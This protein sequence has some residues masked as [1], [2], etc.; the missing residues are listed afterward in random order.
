MWRR[1]SVSDLRRSAGVLVAVSALSQV[2]LEARAYIEE[3]FVKRSESLRFSHCERPSLRTHSNKWR[4]WLSCGIEPRS[5][6]RQSPATTRSHVGD[7]ILV[8]SLPIRYLEAVTVACTPVLY[9]R[10]N[11]RLS[12]KV[13]FVTAYKYM[14][15]YLQPDMPNESS[16]LTLPPSW[17]INS[18]ASLYKSGTRRPWCMNARFCHS[19]THEALAKM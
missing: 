3:A 5:F 15:Y 7:V 2:R 17:V 11:E 13:L 8:S 16:N 10:G 4:W 6:T 14:Y 12:G 9:G 18:Y 1:W 19:T